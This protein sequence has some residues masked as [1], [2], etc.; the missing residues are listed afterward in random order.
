M[1]YFLS[2]DG[3]TKV[4]LDCED[5]ITVNMPSTVTKSS[6]S[7]GKAITHE[8][9][10]GNVTISVSGL[11]TYSKSVAQENNLDPIGLQNELQKARR[12]SR[13]FKLF[14]SDVEDERPLYNDYD[15]CVISDVTVTAE[16]YSNAVRVDISFEQIFV[17]K[18]AKYLIPKSN[19][20]NA[21]TT[22]K[23]TDSGQGSKTHSKSSK[24]IYEAMANGSYDM[25][26]KVK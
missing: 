10:E 11:V 12:D 7:S 5:N 20:D 2:D 22:N 23:P 4:S 24:E 3:S 6:V 16:K 9:I 18:A 26:G 14:M 19:K 21:A 13:K 8:V 17:S 1:V 25:S 15:D